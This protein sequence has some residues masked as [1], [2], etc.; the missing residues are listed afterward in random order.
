MFLRDRPAHRLGLLFKSFL[1]WQRSG[2]WRSVNGATHVNEILV[3]LQKDRPA[4][5]LLFSNRESPEKIVNLRLGLSD[6]HQ[7]GRTV[8]LV[9]LSR[10]RRMI[11][12]PRPG[13]TSWP[14]SPF[15]PG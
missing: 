4:I 14:G 10:D 1:C 6:S 13:R 12:K 15:W 11:Y 3:R 5:A 7:E 2:L 9:Q 8:A